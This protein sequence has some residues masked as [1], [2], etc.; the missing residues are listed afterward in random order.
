MSAS[1]DHRL[2]KDN[3]QSYLFMFPSRSLAELVRAMKL[4]S[5]DEE[6]LK[7]DSSVH[8]QHQLPSIVETDPAVAQA[9]RSAE[10]FY[11]Q[12]MMPQVSY[13]DISF[14]QMKVSL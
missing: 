5:G 12:P 3:L 4:K 11:P 2:E 10:P 14:S 7:E 9:V 1:P 8:H 13:D 6:G